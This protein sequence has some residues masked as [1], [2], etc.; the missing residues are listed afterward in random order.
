MDAGSDARGMSEDNGKRFDRTQEAWSALADQFTQ[1]AHQF[2]EHYHRVTA[3][4]SQVGAQPS[5]GP[6]GAASAGA[7]R[8]STDLVG[9]ASVHADPAGT[10]PG[11]TDTADHRVR[12]AVEDA[13]R[14][15]ENAVGDPKLRQDSAEA[16][17]A[18]LRAVGATLSELGAAIQREGH[19]KQTPRP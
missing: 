11:G 12:K 2:R 7:E 3:G 14:A 9:A 8:V 16:G 13:A 18:L 4:A 6:A 17:S 15:F 10:G 19:D 5:D 1:I